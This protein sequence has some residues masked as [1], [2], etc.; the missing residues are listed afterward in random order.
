MR[1]SGTGSGGGYG[2]RN[3]RHTSNPKSEPR[4]HARNPAKAAQSGQMQG[5]HVTTYGGGK[6]SY[7]GDPE[8]TGAGYSSPVGPT[9]FSN[10][11]VGGGRT[12]H[13]SGSQG[14]HGSTNPGTPRP[15]GK[16][17]LGAFGPES[18]RS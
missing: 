14:V 1:R 7:R 11:G 13:S 9:S 3:V 2:S 17:I 15:A 8:F 16:D 10:T 4:P 6:T 12:I 18:K 5:D